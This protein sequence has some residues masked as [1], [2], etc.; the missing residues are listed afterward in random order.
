MYKINFILTKKLDRVMQFCC[1]YTENMFSIGKQKHIEK[2]MK[3][4]SV[5]NNQRVVLIDDDLNNVSRA[6]ENDMPAIHVDKNG[7][8]YLYRA[9]EILGLGLD[10]LSDEHTVSLDSTSTD[11]G[12]E[13]SGNI[14]PDSDILELT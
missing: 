14:S 8:N 1:K 4:F 6:L 12:L 5:D 2:A 13:L 11:S 7:A 3:H 10:Q 9:S